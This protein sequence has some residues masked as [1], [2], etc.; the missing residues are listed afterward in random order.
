MFSLTFCN[1]TF[2]F[3][4]IFDIPTVPTS[5][6]YSGIHDHFLVSKWNRHM[7][8]SMVTL[9]CCVPMLRGEAGEQR[10]HRHS[11]GRFPWIQPLPLA[12]LLDKMSSYTS[13]PIQVSPKDWDQPSQPC[14]ASKPSQSSI[15]NVN[16]A[17][18]PRQFSPC[19]PAGDGDME[20]RVS[21]L[22]IGSK[23]SG[24]LLR[25]TAWFGEAL[26]LN[27]WKILW[28][29]SKVRL[30]KKSV[31]LSSTSKLFFTRLQMIY[32]VQYIH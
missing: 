28:C 14:Q 29:L 3:D 25:Q 20:T 5:L 7:S 27:A 19:F 24:K 9:G 32:H 6:E 23:C 13:Q 21:T 26:V 15:C 1:M 17:N 4:P 12:N 31:D 11:S 10:P 18:P 16:L 30:L 22:K 2:N 8:E